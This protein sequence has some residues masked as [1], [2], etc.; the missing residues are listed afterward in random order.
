MLR[1]SK[2]KQVL[3]TVFTLPAAFFIY[4]GLSVVLG[5][6][7]YF[8]VTAFVDGYHYAEYLVN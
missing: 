3:I 5:F 4:C 6:V 8:L 1:L 2:M 7:S